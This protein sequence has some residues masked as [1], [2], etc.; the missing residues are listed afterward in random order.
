MY[1]R[2]ALQKEKGERIQYKKSIMPKTD[3]II[4][5]PEVLVGFIKPL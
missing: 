4:L 5:F 1:F 2:E 3:C